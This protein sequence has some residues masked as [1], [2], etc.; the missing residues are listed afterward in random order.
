MSKGVRSRSF[1]SGSSPPIYPLRQAQSPTCTT[2]AP[3]RSSCRRSVALCPRPAGPHVRVDSDRLQQLAGASFLDPDDER[4]WQ[5]LLPIVGGA[6]GA[7]PLAAPIHRSP[8]CEL[9]VG[10]AGL[11]RFPLQQRAL[12]RD[13]LARGQRG[14]EP[15]VPSAPAA[16]CQH[17]AVGPGGSGLLG[18][19]RGLPAARVVRRRRGRL[20]GGAEAHGGR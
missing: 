10:G 1:P 8:A 14:P 15:G 13:H 7:A 3:F 19:L 11:L 6:E 17:P 20:R 5:L 2:P 9:L 18:G 16:D 4:L 12:R